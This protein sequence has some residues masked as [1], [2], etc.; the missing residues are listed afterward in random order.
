MTILRSVTIAAACAV[1]LGS[2]SFADEVSWRALIE[3]GNRFMDENRYA[4]ATET[5]RS[6][7][8]QAQAGHS[9]QMGISLDHLGNAY[10]ALG[11]DQEAERCFQQAIAALESV[12]EEG[13]PYLI[14]AWT[15]LAG[16]HIKFTRYASAR[17]LAERALAALTRQASQDPKA[18]ALALTLLASIDSSQ[19]KTK[20]A[21]VRCRQAMAVLD[22]AG[23]SQSREWS[24]AANN[25]GTLLLG[26]GRPA[27]G[28]HYLREALSRSEETVRTPEDKLVLGLL[29][30]N[31]AT[32]DSRLRRFDEAD[33]YLRRALEIFEG[34]LGLTHP[35]TGTTLMQ[36]AGLCR[37][38]NRKAEAKDYERR[39]KECL[40]A[41]GYSALANTIDVNELRARGR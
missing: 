3:T 40:T 22:R 17:N 19:H 29:L 20:D 2:A 5:F 18:T 10:E 28:E 41:T 31:L 27:E 7:A 11:R 4:A 32:V 35:T 36:Y 12:G 1:C 15:D 9:P 6:A 33:R 26:S 24:A 30:A 21:E 25:L 39:A 13:Y 38:T 8:A 37:A 23:W 14:R 34:E 16:H